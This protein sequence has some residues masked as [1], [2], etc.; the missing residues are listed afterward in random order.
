MK[1]GLTV[2]LLEKHGVPIVSFYALMKTGAA[3][4]PKGQEGLATIT[5]ELLRKGTKARTAQQFAADLDFIGGSFES[6]TPKRILRA[7]LREFLTK[8]LA[9]GWIYLPMRCCTQ[10]FRKRRWTKSWRRALMES[11]AAKDESAAGARRVLQRISCLDASSYGRPANGDELSLKRIRA[12]RDREVS[13]MQTTRRETRFWRWPVNS[14]L[15]RCGR[16][17]KKSSA[18]GRRNRRRQPRC[19][20]APPVKGKRLLLVDKPDATQT[21]FAIGNVGTTVNDPDR[22]AIRSCEHGVWR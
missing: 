13:T 19:P 22:V 4:D 16:N 5:A 21:Y 14:M 1:N 20:A 3:A 7:F 11:E 17:W 12:R 8:D 9:P 2:L 10:L 6:R 15:R 18:R